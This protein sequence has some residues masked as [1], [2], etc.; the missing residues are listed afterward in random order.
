MLV[1]CCNHIALIK[2]ID[3]NDE[4]E[5]YQEMQ[6]LPPPPLQNSVLVPKLWKTSDNVEDFR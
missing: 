3:Q 5:I 2:I 6:V 1:A 4:I